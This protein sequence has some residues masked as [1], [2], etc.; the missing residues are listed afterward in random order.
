MIR[1]V[2][3]KLVTLEPRQAIS[4]ESDPS[5]VNVGNSSVSDSVGL[6]YF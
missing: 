6:G 2:L 3:N 5:L 4:S 1:L